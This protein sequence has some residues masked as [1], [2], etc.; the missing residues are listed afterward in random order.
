M[1]NG[2]PRR[3]LD[4]RQAEE[5]LGFQAATPLREGLAR[6]IDVVPR[7]HRLAPAR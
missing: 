5:L 1:P 2:Q 7:E 4:T 3:R 6:T